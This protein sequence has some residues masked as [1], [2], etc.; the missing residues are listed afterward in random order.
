MHWLPLRAGFTDSKFHNTALGPVGA[1]I[2]PDETGRFDSIP[3]L[4]AGE[5]NSNTEFSDDQKSGRL[6]GLTMNPPDST[7]GQWRTSGIRNVAQTAPYMH[8][9][10][11]AQLKDVVHFYNIGPG[12]MA[13]DAAPPCAVSPPPMTVQPHAPCYYGKPDQLIKPLNLSDAEE[14]QLVEFM[15]TLTGDPLPANLAM[16]TSIPGTGL[17]DAA[18]DEPTDAGPT[19]D[20][21]MGDASGD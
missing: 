8:T 10:Q 19:A 15:K 14:N 20:A 7:I 21:G 11:F 1:H 3:A 16:D 12:P 4:L 6:D 5:F 9:G 13:A 2:A 17:P 18:F